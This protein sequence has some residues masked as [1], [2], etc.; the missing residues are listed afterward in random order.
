MH[1]VR[2]GF[3]AALPGRGT[4]GSRMDVESL[5]AEAERRI[6]RGELR[7][8]LA[9]YEQVAA[10]KP[11]DATAAGK[12]ATLRELIAPDGATVPGPDSFGPRGNPAPTPAPRTPGAAPTQTPEQRA[13]AH[14]EA[15]DFAA[16]LAAWRAILAARPDHELARERVRELESLV[17]AA[18][19]GAGRAPTGA[20]PAAG[21]PE[22][23]LR[24]LLERIAA[25]R[26]R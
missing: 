10:H 1:A 6:K 23:V 3:F 13:E 18:A 2:A 14:F 17:G 26:R 25:R 19:P 7:E 4:V 21:P 12:V 16:A 8:A 15:G 9:L 22:A 20:P 11:G 24:D 5:R